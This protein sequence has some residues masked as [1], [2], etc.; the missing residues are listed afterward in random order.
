MLGEDAGLW[1]PW[2]LLRP[3]CL[4]ICLLL[5]FCWALCWKASS[6]QATTAPSHGA[7]ENDRRAPS[8]QT[9]EPGCGFQYQE[10]RSGVEEH[11]GPLRQASEEEAQ[12]RDGPAPPGDATP[13]CCL[14]RMHAPGAS[15]GA[16]SAATR[17]Q[18][19]P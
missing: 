8:R 14:R 4:I 10:P 13:K 9:R 16:G 5:D 7:Q 11:G 2:W 17:P 18:A 12:H 1:G 19:Q 6:W 15:R 3:R